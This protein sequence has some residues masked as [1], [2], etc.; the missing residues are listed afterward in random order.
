MERITDIEKLIVNMKDAGCSDADISRVAGMH[1]AGL[2]DEIVRCLRRCRCEL[3][4]E[5]HDSQR[6]LDCMDQ[7]IRSAEKAAAR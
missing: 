4:D 3:M 5:L 7:L 6:R 2:D 1:E